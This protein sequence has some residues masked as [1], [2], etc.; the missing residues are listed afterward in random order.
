MVL[1]LI[2]KANA[3]LCVERLFKIRPDELLML[4]D[5]SEFCNGRFAATFKKIT[6]D[7]CSGQPRR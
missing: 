3:V 6:E 2:K 4:T 1:G 5:D 7:T